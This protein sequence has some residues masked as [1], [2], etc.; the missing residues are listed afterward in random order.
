MQHFGQIL[1]SIMGSA[2][3]IAVWIS[4]TFVFLFK[5][6]GALSSKAFLTLSEKP[7]DTVFNTD[8]I[9]EFATFHCNAHGYPKP[10]IT[11]LANDQIIR[12][13]GLYSVAEDGSLRISEPTRLLNGSTYRC[14]ANNSFGAVMSEAALLEIAYVGQV[15]E[16][17]LP[18]V[19]V[20]T[21]L[22]KCIT[23]NPPNAYP[24]IKVTWVKDT[25]W[26]TPNE[27]VTVMMDGR[28]CFAHSQIGDTGNFH[29]LV[30]NR[31]DDGGAASFTRGSSVRFSVLLGGSNPPQSLTPVTGIQE[32]VTVRQGQEAVLEC[33][34]LGSPTPTLSWSRRGNGLPTNSTMSRHNQTLRIPNAQPEDGGEYECTGETSDGDSETVYRRLTVLAPPFLVSGLED[35]EVEPGRNVTLQCTADSDAVEFSWYHNAR[36]INSSMQRPRISEDNTLTIDNAMVEDSGIYQCAARNEHGMTLSTAQLFVKEQDPTEE[37]PV[38]SEINQPNVESPGNGA[39]NTLVHIFSTVVMVSAVLF[40]VI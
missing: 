21:R 13:N 39:G 17:Q 28:L 24:G 30:S 5:I 3:E 33:F 19:S 18:D 20:N 11:W 27:R 31:Y 36:L 6:G 16:V 2:M 14:I 32:S 26:L 34:F 4:I 10:D 29:C 1:R 23:C 22:G 35:E 25:L 9:R 7:K 15:L 8:S 37:N 40:E 38:E 12:E